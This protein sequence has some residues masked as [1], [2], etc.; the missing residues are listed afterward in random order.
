MNALVRGAQPQDAA[1]IAALCAE[2]G[3]AGTAQELHQRLL[4]LAP[5]PN[6]WVGVAEVAGEPLL[7]WIHVGRRFTLQDG[8][9]AEILGLVTGEQ[10]RRRGV[11]RALVAAAEAWARQQGALRLKVRS[12]IARVQSHEFYPALGFER[13]KTQHVYVKALTAVTP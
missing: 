6:D 11:G 1:D 3:Y 2:L 8:Q 5:L 12:N 7:G 13:T 9:S 4:C 10:V